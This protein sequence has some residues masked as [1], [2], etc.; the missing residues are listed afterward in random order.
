MNKAVLM[1][2][3]F[4]GGCRKILLY[5]SLHMF[6]LRQFLRRMEGL[7]DECSYTHFSPLF[8]NTHGSICGFQDEIV[9]TI[10]GWNLSVFYGTFYCEKAA[11]IG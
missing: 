9:G 2:F 5:G 1:S 6:F 10:F 3:K 4:S 8:C 11:E 7:R